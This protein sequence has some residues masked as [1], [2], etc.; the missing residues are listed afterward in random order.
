MKKLKTT[1]EIDYS[2]NYVA[3]LRDNF[4]S[5]MRQKFWEKTVS[6][7]DKITYLK[8]ISEAEWQVR[9]AVSREYP[10]MKDIESYVVKPN[11]I[12]YEEETHE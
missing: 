12:F 2:R 5:I 4:E 10:F 9:E 6:I 11:G 8:S 3:L 7:Q 1:K